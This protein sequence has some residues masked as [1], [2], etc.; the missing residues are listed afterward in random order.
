[1]TS[2]VNRLNPDQYIWRHVR[3]H[4]GYLFFIWGL[5]WV[6]PALAAD[7]KVEL[8]RD[9]WGNPLTSAQ[10]R[11]IKPLQDMVKK[12]IDLPSSKL[13]IFYPDTDGGRKWALQVVEWL[14][15]LGLGS[16]RIELHPGSEKA[17]VIELEIR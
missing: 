3:W 7:E 13:I 1:M 16:E 12:L 9:Q 17:D 14:V 5:L 11:Q 4:L 15:S 6:S 2:K 8:S 10:V